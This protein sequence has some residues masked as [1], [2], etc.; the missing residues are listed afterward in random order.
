M[1]QEAV[2][3]VDPISTGGSV[4]FEAYTRGYAVIA[5]WC[6]ELTP[7]FKSHLPDCCLTNFSFYAEV[8][9]G[10]KTIAETAAAVKKAADPM[11]IVAVIVGG[12]SG[13]TLADK[14]S[15]ELKVRSNGIFPF[16][17]RRNKS[18]QQ[19]AVKAAGM[20]AVREALGKQWSAVEAFVESEPM[21]VVVKPV[22][23]C[24][25]DGVKLC[26]T[27]EEAKEHFNLLMDS[28]RKV[29]AQDAAVLV[30]EFLKG[31]EYVIDH[32]SR[33]GVHK[34]VM[35]YVYDKRPTN[36]AAFV[37]YG[38]I[39]VDAESKEAKIL[40]DYTRGVLDALKLDNGP[41]HGEVM[42]T[43]DGPCLVEMNCRSHG[44]DGAWVPLAKALTGGY[45][46]PAVALDSHVDAEAFAKIPD[47]YPSPF[48]AAG[49]TVMLVSFFSGII[50]STPG[51]DKMRKMRSFVALQTGYKVGSEVTLTVD[52]FS[53]VGVLIL[54]HADKKVL[55]EDLNAV[56]EMEKTGL[57]EFEEEIDPVT[58]EAS[59]D[60]NIQR[61]GAGRPIR[62]S[63]FNGNSVKPTEEKSMLLPVAVALGVGALVGILIG[64]NM[65]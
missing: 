60:L 7:E 22:E 48:K 37:Y 24:G 15:T 17:D 34:C 28:Q 26:R 54:A 49:Q 14:L 38:M 19:K 35:V 2:V 23:S 42:M 58:Y 36:G 8:E 40:I 13:V 52:L 47:V 43:A 61:V 25:S 27:K 4:A 45:A 62:T 31:Q 10:E 50:K 20:R 55:E 1:A 12:E 5:C 16:G 32:V 46:Q 63:S 11:K 51:Y 3:I 56:R 59:P 64:K 44:W 33:D 9:E 39:P 57:F 29:G 21:P 18:V 41:T 30:Q 53:A 65:K 6:N